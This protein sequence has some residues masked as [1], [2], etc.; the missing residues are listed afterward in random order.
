MNYHLYRKRMEACIRDLERLRSGI[1]GG[2]VNQE[3]R[4]LIDKSIK[5]LRLSVKGILTKPEP[6]KEERE[7]E[8]AKPRAGIKHDLKSEQE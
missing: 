8:Q 4:D 3:S 5:D 2:A 1:S 6:K 7:D